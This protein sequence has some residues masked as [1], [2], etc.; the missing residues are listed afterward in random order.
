MPYLS[1]LEMSYTQYKALY[2]RRVYMLISALST[3]NRNKN[4]AVAEMGDRLATVDMG[5]MW[6][7]LCPFQ[8]GSWFPHNA[9]WPGPRPISVPSGILIHPTDWPQDI[10]VTDRQ[11][12]Q[13]GQRPRSIQQTVTCNGRPKLNTA[14][15]LLS[16]S[17]T[18]GIPSPS[19]SLSLASF[20]PSLSSS[21]SR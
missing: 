11:D 3:G 13:T 7:L 4:S 9:M 18:S 1:I 10:N 15:H 14:A 8:L 21:E 6:G 12:R 20:F 5:R 19:S 16:G 2:K 17:R